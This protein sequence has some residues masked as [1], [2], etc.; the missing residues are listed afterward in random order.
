[1]LD[2]NGDDAPDD[3]TK[4]NGD[5]SGSIVSDRAD[6][7]ANGDAAGENVGDDDCNDEGI[8]CANFGGGDF[9]VQD[10]GDEGYIDDYLNDTDY[11]KTNDRDDDLN[12][13]N[14]GKANDSDDD[15]ADSVTNDNCNVR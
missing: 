13:S 2:G 5:M 3:I 10:N 1:M 14:G 12:D 7:N 9:D 4:G 15:Y 6:D 11:D 8:A